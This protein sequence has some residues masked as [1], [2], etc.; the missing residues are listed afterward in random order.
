VRHLQETEAHASGRRIA[1]IGAGIAGLSAA[2]LLSRR[3]H[4]TLYEKNSW[5]G[6]HAN[7]VDV[8]CPGGRIAV[9]TGFIVFNGRT[10]PNFTALLEHLGV[11]L[12]RHRHDVRS[13]DR[14]WARRVFEPPAGGVRAEAQP[15]QRPVLA[16]ALRHPPLL[17]ACARARRNERRRCEPGA[18]PRTRR[19]FAR[20]GRAPRHADVRR[21]LVDDAAGNPRLSDAFV[22]ALLFEPRPPAHGAKAGLAHRRGGSRAMSRRCWPTWA[23]GFGSRPALLRVQIRRDGGL[24]SVEDAS[25]ETQRLH[26]RGH[27]GACRRRS[28]GCLPIRPPDEQRILGSFTYTPNRAVLH[29]D[30]ALMP[31]R[32]AVWASW[33]YIGSNDARPTRRS[34]SPTG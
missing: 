20:T 2:W 3:H 15:R 21:H 14:R 22:P 26:R 19:V 1:V 18:V 8:D 31:R 28:R 7:T 32:K 33:N 23:P 16:D 30:P 11:A 25:G 9:D 17:C 10:Y 29:D 6:G 34:A 12:Q 13:V 27:R 4:V 24:T 5:L